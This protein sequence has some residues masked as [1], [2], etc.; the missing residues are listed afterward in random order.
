M[1]RGVDPIAAKRTARVEA[2]AEAERD[3]LTLEVLV[4]DWTRKH[5]AKR[6]DRYRLEAVR[7]LKHAFVAQWS[8]LP[9]I[10][11][12][13]LFAG[14]WTALTGAGPNWAT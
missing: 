1:R 2:R 12:E 9:R 14:C 10:W 13:Q 6:S 8:S 7:A 3:R 4:G 5:L 11:T